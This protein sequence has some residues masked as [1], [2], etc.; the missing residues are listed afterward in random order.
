MIP[1]PVD[2]TSLV[3]SVSLVKQIGICLFLFLCFFI[4]CSSAAAAPGDLDTNFGSNGYATYSSSSKTLEQIAPTPDGGIVVVDDNYEGG[5]T[6][7][8]QVSKLT[9]SGQLDTDFSGDGKLI[10]DTG[11][12]SGFYITSGISKIAVDPSTGDIYIANLIGDSS[13]PEAILKIYALAPDGTL[14]STFNGGS[15]ITLSDSGYQHIVGL[16][17]V[18]TSAGPGTS[19]LQVALDY[20]PGSTSGLELLRY[21]ATDGIADSGF[22]SSGHK[23]VSLTSTHCE[24]PTDAGLDKDA[25]TR[26]LFQNCASGAEDQELEEVDSNGDLVTSY[27]AGDGVIH[28]AYIDNDSAVAFG[29][30]GDVFYAPR[31]DAG[32][33]R[34][35]VHYL[36][37]GALDGYYGGFGSSSIND[38]NNMRLQSFAN[39]YVMAASCNNNYD[40]LSLTLLDSQGYPFNSFGV[41]GTTAASVDDCGLESPAVQSSSGNFDIG[42]SNYDPDQVIQFS[43]YPAPNT[44]GDSSQ[45]GPGT[46]RNPQT[47]DPV[48]PLTGN[49]YLS[50]TDFMVKAPGS[51]VSWIRSYNSQS[52]VDGPLGIGWTDP[53]NAYLTEDTS[54]GNVVFTDVDGHTATFDHDPGTSSYSSPYDD[55]DTLVKNGDGS[56][57]LT[58]RNGTVWHFDTDGR[59]ASITDRAGNATV[60]NYSSGKLTQII[61]S[62]GRAY[63]ISYGTGADADHITAISFPGSTPATPRDITYGYDAGH[64]SSYTDAAGDQTTYTYDPSGQIQTMTTPGD[65]SDPGAQTSYTY[66]DS[67]RAVAVETDDGAVSANYQN[68]Y[69]SYDPAS[70]QTTI[71]DADGQETLLTYDITGSL[72]KVTDPD[73]DVKSYTY[74]PDGQVASYTDPGDHTTSYQYDAQGDRTAIILPKVHTSDTDNPETDFTYNTYGQV[75][76]ATDPR[77]EET[78]YIY[79]PGTGALTE[80][81]QPNNSSVLYTYDPLNNPYDLPSEMTDALGHETDYT[82]DAAGNLASVTAVDEPGRPTWLYTSDYAGRPLSEQEPLGVASGLP[83]AYTSNTSYTPDDQIDTITEPSDDGTGPE[84]TL[85]YDYDQRN[86]LIGET[87]EN[88]HTTTYTYSPDNQLLTSTDPDGVLTT[89]DYDSFG[90][91]IS[92]VDGSGNTTEYS[93]DH[94]QLPVAVVSGAGTSDQTETDY[95]YAPDGTMT[96]K[97]VDPGSG[98]HLN[99]VTT[100]AYDGLGRLEQVTQHDGSTPITS[101]YT[102]NLEGSLL[103]STDPDGNTTTYGYNAIG[104]LN[105]RMNA[106]QSDDHVHWTWNYDKNGNVTK[107]IDPDGTQITYT[108]DA[109]GQLTN[110]NLPGTNPDISRG[111]DADGNLTTMT[112]AVGTSSYTYD[113]RDRMISATQPTSVI[114]SNTIDYSYYPDN[115]LATVDYPLGLSADYSY[116]DAGRLDS[117]TDQN[118]NVTSLDYNIGSGGNGSLAQISYPDDGGT[119][120][121]DYD[122]LGRI[123]ELENSSPG[124]MGLSSDASLTYDKAGNLLNYSDSGTGISGSSTY[125][126]LNRLTSEDWSGLS[127][128]NQDLSYTYDPAGNRLTSTDNGTVTTDTYNYDESLESETTNWVSSYYNYDETGNML[129]STTPGGDN[130]TY[131]YTPQEQLKHANLPGTAKDQAY[132]YDGNGQL[133]S[134]ATGPAASPDIK[135]LEYDPLLSGAA[136]GPI[137]ETDTAG[138]SAPSAFNL[139][140]PGGQLLTRSYQASGS[141]GN[142]AVIAPIAYHDDPFGSPSGVVDTGTGDAIASA[143]YGAFGNVLDSGGAEPGSDEQPYAYLDRLQLGAAGL[144]QF[145]A[146]AYDPARGRFTGQDPMVG[147]DPETP[148]TLDPYSYGMNAPYAEQD[149]SGL[150]ADPYWN[151][152]ASQD[153][154]FSGMPYQPSGEGPYL[155]AQSV[156]Y[157]NTLITYTAGSHDAVCI[158]QEVPEGCYYLNAEANKTSVQA[159][160]ILLEFGGGFSE[161][162]ARRATLLSQALRGGSSEAARLL[163]DAGRLARVLGPIARA[164]PY[165]TALLDFYDTYEEDHNLLKAGASAGGGLAGGAIGVGVGA[166][167]CAGVALLSDGLGSASCFITVPVFGAAGGF[168]GADFAKSLAP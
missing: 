21:G 86:N 129:T 32:G 133:A 132:T 109:L 157:G 2:K 53:Y 1:S 124:S 6:E 135:D 143:T 83:G 141:S 3:P 11:T 40:T 150:Y 49:V 117:V 20:F 96:S 90:N 161:G 111:Y 92:S 51:S 8:F 162:A 78:D 146:R 120:D 10:L 122:P 73:G 22:G 76:S 28:L 7:T 80:I 154:P 110:T 118:G 91:V 44:P 54:S 38:G 100:Y 45:F 121:Y 81:D 160:A 101:S 34:K 155:P 137:L 47:G 61:D 71:T 57:D 18:N 74:T 63:T 43:G 87:D 85:S 153:P 98:T 72:V 104:L 164:A 12:I 31:P 123:S 106:Q 95:V 68:T 30:D 5:S 167:A 41:D 58:R 77:G 93:Y 16:G 67:G 48:N 134:I 102:Y 27:H 25:N 116:D 39:G 142:L 84:D 75:T 145:N 14:L 103:T 115:Q 108:Y 60:L 107:S 130:V 97:I 64:L 128:G 24:I 114:T 89:Y 125:D 17:F 131:T 50:N 29:P 168:F 166:R 23:F 148:Q 119:S 138:V 82:Y 149:I 65:T 158:Y 42:V 62:A 13:G 4:L 156:S 165:A 144:D 36:P 139:R 59:L 127:I 94:E 159:L 69:Y 15:A 151:G 70:E 46:D 19:D 112:D 136:S 52:T 55:F 35:V 152:A 37:G 9:S 66:D 105:S 113:Q 26:V 126:N 99:E 147:T 88:G 140:A 33:P 56:Y 163:P 79:D